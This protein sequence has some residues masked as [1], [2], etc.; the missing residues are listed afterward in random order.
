MSIDH[1]VWVARRS[2]K[3]VQRGANDYRNPYERDR[4]RVV[5]SAAFR[6]LQ[7]KTQVFGVHE[8]DFHRTRLTHSIEVSSVA[9]NIAARLVRGNT[10]TQKL[11]ETLQ[12]TSF[13]SYSQLVTTIS[14]LH[15]I[16]HPPFGHAGEYALD[17]VMRDYGGFEANGQTLRLLTCLE[18]YSPDNPYGL[19]LTRR[20]LLGLLKYPCSY[21]QLCRREPVPAEPNMPWFIIPRN[22]HPPK[23][24]LDTEQEVVDWLLAPLTSQDRALFQTYYSGKDQHYMTKHKSFDCSIMDLA[25]DIAYG[26]HDLE[27]AIVLKIVQK[28]ALAE[29]K[30]TPDSPTVAQLLSNIFANRSSSLL[31]DLFSGDSYYRKQAIGDLVNLFIGAARL[32]ELPDFVNPLLRY[33]VVIT[34]DTVR[35]LLQSL[36][37]FVKST[38]VETHE[39]ATIRHGGQMIIL[40][41]FAAFNA[42]WDRLLDKKDQEKINKQLFS[43]ERVVCDYIAGMTDEYARRMYERLFGLGYRTMF[44]KI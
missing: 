10:L 7:R 14:L 28:E 18:N 20:T 8:S 33:H 21:T 3:Q 40:H 19:D 24:Y 31:H 15:D 39:A 29:F 34:D 37:Q 4:C 6:R 16:G 2:G 23:A 1:A 5:H 32:K 41:L 27:D 36:M 26:A 43:K 44:E 42:Q 17:Y 11:K 38:I 13:D 12:L 22:W 30:I 35:Q 9:R 25:D